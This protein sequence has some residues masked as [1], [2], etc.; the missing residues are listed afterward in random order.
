M[1]DLFWV[2][3]SWDI[4][5][6]AQ[7]SK[8]KYQNLQTHLGKNEDLGYILLRCTVTTGSRFSEKKRTY[9]ELGKMKVN[10]LYFGDV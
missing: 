5:T 1:H 6:N 4:I 8:C 10:T 2:I 3:D 9:G 7:P